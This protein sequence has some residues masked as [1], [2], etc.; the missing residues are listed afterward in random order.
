[1]AA[2]AS[3]APR[4]GMAQPAP[5]GGESAAPALAAQPPA[6]D[7]QDAVRRDLEH[8]LG[9]LKDSA[10]PM[11]AR[12]EAARRLVGRGTPEA[13][14][15]LLDLLREGRDDAQI[16]IARALAGAPEPDLRFIGPLG[17]LLGPNVILTEAVARAL[18]SYKASEEARDRLLHFVNTTN[19]SERSREAV[20]RAMG[21]LV[22]QRTAAGLIDL[23]NTA[24]ES[25]RVRSAALDGL[26]EMTGET[27]NG[28]D[29]QRWNNW[30]AASRNM[31]PA[32][33]GNQ[34]LA[35]KAVRLTDMQQ[36]M[37]T[38]LSSY[39]EQL[40][41]D[42]ARTPEAE[43]GAFIAA[44][45]QDASEDVRLM[46]VS[47]ASEE[48]LQGRRSPQV[49]AVLRERIGDSSIEVRK[50]VASTLRYWNDPGA[51]DALLAQL[52][53]ETDTDV[54]VELIG[55]LGP[56]RDIRAVDPLIRLLGDETIAVAKAAAD[57]LKDPAMA[58]ELRKEANRDR[59]A[60]VAGA[61]LA[62]LQSTQEKTPPLRLLRQSVAEAMGALGHVTFKEAF[63]SLI[64]PTNEP[65]SR[66]RVAAL[67]GLGLIEDVNLANAIVGALK[68]EANTVRLVACEA[69]RTCGTFEHAGPLKDLLFA[70][71]EPDPTI[72][73]AAWET[74]ML[75]FA[76]A[77]DAH[78]LDFWAQLFKNNNPSL[79]DRQR[80]VDIFTLQEKMLLGAVAAKAVG[81]DRDLALIHQTLGDELLALGQAD[82]ANIKARSEEAARRFRAALDYWDKTDAPDTVRVR[83][84]LSQQYAEALLRARR[85]TDAAQ[86]ISSAIK[87][88][89]DAGVMWARARDE[90]QRLIKLDDWETADALMIEIKKITWTG[91]QAGPLKDLDTQ[92]TNRTRTGGFIWVNGTDAFPFFPFPF[93]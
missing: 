60:A 85:F 46:G 83:D 41:R 57:S 84:T 23:I 78:N 20:A 6:G 65:D 87:G 66:I 51:V 16:A 64:I 4:L 67:R 89:M 90:V 38:L 68:D 5:S 39:E 73:K 28:R 50:R 7:S 69:L 40:R 53:Q 18:A 31:G 35:N 59:A 86:F 92:V 77:P 13:D 80:R 49:L 21:A 81:A 2:A 82:E 3:A 43:R 63:A 62:R 34:V 61:L 14:I 27:V 29:V 19:Q 10:A 15:I 56:T 74:A 93:A 8:Q 79:E 47:L 1:M 26:L 42:F 9:I 22:D 36:R 30:W 45:I 54:R 24:D 91:L 25:A 48:L 12:E 44:R 55:A 52:A 71:S 88:G 75:L 70:S 76:K 17:N 33:W 72:R 58:A 37:R 11:Q 32:Q